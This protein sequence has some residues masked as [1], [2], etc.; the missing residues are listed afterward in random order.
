MTHVNGEI[1]NFIILW[2]YIGQLTY[3]KHQYVEFMANFF[4]SAIKNMKN[5]RFVVIYPQRWANCMTNCSQRKLIVVMPC[6]TG[7]H[8]THDTRLS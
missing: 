2:H 4:Y 6:M 5:I 3:L 7:Y 1:K 8:C